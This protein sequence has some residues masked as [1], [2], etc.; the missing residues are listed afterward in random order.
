VGSGWFKRLV[1]RSNSIGMDEAEKAKLAEKRLDSVIDEVEAEGLIDEDAQEMI[2]GVIDFS[3]SQVRD[4]MVPRTEVVA[5]DVNTPIDQVIQTILQSGHSRI[6]AYEEAIDR[7]V[8]LVYAKDLLSRW[9]AERI[10]LRTVLREAYFIPETK[11]LDDLLDEFRKK[12]MHLAIVIDEYGGTSGLVTMEDLIEE[13]V[14]EIVDEYDD[15]VTLLQKIS[16]NEVMASARLEVDELFDHFD[17]EEP[18]GKFTTIGGWIFS[19]T[20]YIPQQGE[21]IDIDGMRVVVEAADERTVKRVRIALKSPDSTS[22]L[23]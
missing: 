13:I 23:S 6:P 19:H 7:I 9:G 15:D 14:G 1:G 3:S 17:L 2:R 4:V 18:E 20:G 12:H 16:D 11:P 5:V 21:A 22:E 10:D 8:G